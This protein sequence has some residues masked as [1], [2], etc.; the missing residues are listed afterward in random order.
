M[1]GKLVLLSRNKR[2]IFTRKKPINP[3]YNMNQLDSFKKGQVF[4]VHKNK[5]DFNFYQFD[6][7][8]WVEIK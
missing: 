1:Y 7:K 6:G 4:I 2:K 3:E 8:N 5:D